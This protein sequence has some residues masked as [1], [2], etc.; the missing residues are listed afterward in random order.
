MDAGWQV[1]LDWNVDDPKHLARVQ[2]IQDAIT[3]YNLDGTEG[4]PASPQSN[5]AFVFIAQFGGSWKVVE[6][7]VLR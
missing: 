2:L 4:R 6:I 5:G 1:E 7:G 3:Y